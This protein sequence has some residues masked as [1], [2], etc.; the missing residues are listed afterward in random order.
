MLVDAV[1]FRKLCRATVNYF[2]IREMRM[3][4]VELVDWHVKAWSTSSVSGTSQMLHC[5]G[6]VVDFLFWSSSLGLG[7]SV[8]S[9]LHNMKTRLSDFY[10]N[11]APPS[12]QIS[13]SSLMVTC[14]EIYRGPNSQ[15]S[16]F[17]SWLM[18]DKSA[19]IKRLRM[20]DQHPDRKIT[21]KS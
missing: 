1:K 15:V 7:G 5:W 16:L 2:T 9:H 6:L 12:H 4:L 13:R 14:A 10:Y 19:I 11:S 17:E 21:C 18:H 3:T 20:P 8:V